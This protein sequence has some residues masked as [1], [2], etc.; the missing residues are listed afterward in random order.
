M[1]TTGDDVQAMVQDARDVPARDTTRA[2]VLGTLGVVLAVVWPVGLP[3][4]IATLRTTRGTGGTARGLGIAGVVLSLLAVLAWGY[5]LPGVVDQAATAARYDREAVSQD[6]DRRALELAT[7]TGT[8]FDVEVELRP[9][10]GSS[11]L[12]DFWGV[13]RADG[14]TVYI[15]TVTNTRPV[16]ANVE[17]VGTLVRDDPGSTPTAPDVVVIATLEPG[18]SGE[19]VVPDVYS[20][21]LGGPATAFV[22]VHTPTWEYPVRGFWQH[23]LAELQWRVGDL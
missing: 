23:M 22:D 18:A 11:V 20:R 8:R 3:V 10:A 2:R 17:V 15:A 9:G 7:A 6:A 1:T 14:T 5:V 13:T 12:D 4:S 19:I 16:R 21:R